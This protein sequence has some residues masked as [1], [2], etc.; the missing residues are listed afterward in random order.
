MIR[1][2]SDQDLEEVWSIINEGAEAYKG[3]IPADCL[4]EPYMSLEEL[5]HETEAGIRF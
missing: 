5:T 4:G 2:C 3:F 1:A